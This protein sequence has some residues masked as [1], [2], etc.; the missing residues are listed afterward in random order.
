MEQERYQ[1]PIRGRGAAHNPPNRFERLRMDYD[2]AENEGRHPEQPT[3]YLKD[4][5]HSIIAKNDSPDIP[6]N[7]SV[8]P[9]RGCEHGCMYCY[10]RPGHEYLGFSPGLDFE[11]RIVVK[12][13]APSL[14]RAELASPR[15]EPEP[16][17]MSGVTDP[18]QP[19]ERKLELTRQCLQVMREFMNPV[20]LITKNHLITRDI[21]ILEPMARNN[22]ARAMISI[23]T[24]DREL[25]GKMEPRTSQP[26]RRLEAVKKLSE[27]GIPVGVMVAPIVPGLTDH[28][29]P[30]LLEAA[31]EAG[32]RYAGH[33]IVRLPHQLKE[34]FTDWLE[35]HYPDRRDKVINKLLSLRD[36]KMNDSRFGHRFAAQGAYAEQIHQTMSV[37]K[38][39]Y[40]F[41][42]APGPLSTDH[43]CGP[44][45]QQLSLF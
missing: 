20:S 35:K 19:V 32:A 37:Y 36:G 18:Y 23:T 45:R 13:K 15:W 44:S 2:A 33:T 8:N 42:E 4:H 17:V 34:L 3:E 16:L 38:K 6:F 29:V 30:K 21:D 24:L 9:Y 25:A 5:T 22:A 43:F 26:M 39:R 27:A 7:K 40:G 10:A 31:A 28:E 41:R 14:L 11:S 12:E 1:N